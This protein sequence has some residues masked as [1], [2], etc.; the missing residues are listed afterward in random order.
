MNMNEY[1]KQARET[2]VYPEACSLS[3]TILG[4]AGEAGE[5]ANL[6]KKVLRDDN[7]ILS[8]A[9]SIKLADELGDVLL[10]LSN[11]ASELGYSLNEVAELNLAKLRS[12][13]ARNVLQGS[14]DNR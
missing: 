12:R 5:V 2:A 6:Y 1:Q 4:L 10:Y 14:G 7:G 11:I 13:K 9:K 3:Y 8:E